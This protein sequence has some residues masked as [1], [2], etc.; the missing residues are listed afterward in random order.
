MEFNLE[1]DEDGG[2]L[3]GK[4][5]VADEDI[6]EEEEEEVSP[7]EGWLHKVLCWYRCGRM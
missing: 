1:G 3:E 5:G 4:V 2:K 7:D 6:K